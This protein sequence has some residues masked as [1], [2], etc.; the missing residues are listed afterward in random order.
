MK[1]LNEKLSDVSFHLQSL[2]APEFSSEVKIAVEKKDRNSLVGICE[3]AKVPTT[4]L[5]T[6]VSVLLSVGPDQPKWPSFF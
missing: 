5:S 1:T 6:V 2:A 4:Y 3:K